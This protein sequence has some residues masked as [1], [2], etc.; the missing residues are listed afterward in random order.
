MKKIK[1]EKTRQR[2]VAI[3][4]AIVFIASAIVAI[5]FAVQNKKALAVE[6]D[7]FMDTPQITVL[8]HGLG[9]GASHW[10][11]ANGTGSGGFAEDTD[12]L[13]YK[14]SEKAGGA[15]I[16]R[17]ETNTATDAN[18]EKHETYS[19]SYTLYEN[20]STNPAATDKCDCITDVSKHIIIVFD[21]C[22]TISKNLPHSICAIVKTAFWYAFCT[23]NI[24]FL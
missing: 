21:V 11:T 24:S 20:Y 15:Y 23:L 5:N 12:S 18:D 3:I 13:V 9:G 7:E 6:N 1:T 8:T 4:L 2:F 19:T 16:Y 14:L 17:A 22:K 10:S